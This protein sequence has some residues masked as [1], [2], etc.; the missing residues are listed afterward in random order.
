MN[1]GS[2]FFDEDFAFHDGETGEKLF[3]VLGTSAGTSVVVKTTS[4]QH[5]RGTAYG[6]QP[7]DRFHNFFIPPKAT[8]LKKETWVCLNEFYEIEARK[9]LQKSFDG[10]IKPVCDLAAAVIRGIQDCAL[11]S[12]DISETQTDVVRSC[13]V[14][15][16]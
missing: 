8:Y 7:R 14:Q 4:V 10:K 3:V 11:Q 12:E 5:G 13:L 1:P 9:A 2:V 16:S 6:C 15:T